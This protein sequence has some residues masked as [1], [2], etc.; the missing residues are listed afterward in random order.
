MGKKPGIVI[1]CSD[2]KFGSSILIDQWHR[3]RGWDN[4]GYHFVI[5]NGQVE[6]NTFMECMD[7]SIERGR[8]I[9]K[10]GAH[11]KGYNDHIGIC[12]IGVDRFTDAQFESL[13]DLL[14]ELRR[15]Y[16]IDFKNVIG[17]NEV[18]TKSCPNFNVQAYLKEF[19]LP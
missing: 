19:I 14:L 10:S 16:Q 13:K 2:S 15:K 12:L 17:H 9:D 8:D 6:N 5:L 1:H 3:E 4:V 18:S 11:A 7:G